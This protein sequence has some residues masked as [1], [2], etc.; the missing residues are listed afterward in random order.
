MEYSFDAVVFDMD[1][2]ITKTALVHGAAWKKMFDDFM[3]LRSEKNGE[4]FKEFTHENDYLPYV[5]GKPRYK[6][7][8]S[9]LESRGIDIPY[10]D[11]NDSPDKET[12]CGLGNKKNI[13]FNEILE[14]DGIEMYDSTIHLIRQLK[15]AGIRVPGYFFKNLDQG[16]LL[17]MQRYKDNPDFDE[18][19]FEIK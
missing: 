4:P 19:F 16:P 12:V 10:G 8:A 2:V 18:S 9:F 6:G 17:F 14:R 13:V 5:D 1:G 7:V 3:K 11:V 15:E